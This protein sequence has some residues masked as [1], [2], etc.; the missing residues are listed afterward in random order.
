M[1]VLVIE[2][3]DSVRTAVRRALLLDGFEVLAV[4]TGQEGVLKA[5]LWFLT[6]SF[7]IL[8]C[9]T[10]MGWRCAAGCGVSA[11]EHRS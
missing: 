2:D 3:D 7:L 6:R 1:R 9:P 8:A 11:I 4:P 10:L 5:R